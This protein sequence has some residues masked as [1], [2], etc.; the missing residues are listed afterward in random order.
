MHGQ[1]LSPRTSRAQ[2]KEKEDEIS[3]NVRW[4]GLEVH[5]G[6]GLVRHVGQRSVPHACQQRYRWHLEKNA[7]QMPAISWR[8]TI[9]KS[10]DRAG[11]RLVHEVVLRVELRIRPVVLLRRAVARVAVDRPL[12]LAAGA[13]E[14]RGDL[15]A[16]GGEQVAAADALERAILPLVCC[17][18]HH[19]P[20]A[21]RVERHAPV[22]LREAMRAVLRNSKRRE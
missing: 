4:T 7:T 15:R 19:V 12:R 1:Y 13:G 14:D 5:D 17:V 18:T 10:D 11:G 21:Q 16:R 8:L 20:K 3:R 9:L 6:T 2:K 22:D